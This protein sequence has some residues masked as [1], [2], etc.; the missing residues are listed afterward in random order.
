MPSIR[1]QYEACRSCILAAIL[2]GLRER[3]DYIN[4]IPRNG[5][6]DIP[7]T[8]LALELSP[9]EGG[10]GLSLRLTEDFP[11][12]DERYTSADW[13][14]FDFTEGCSSPSFEAARAYFSEMYKQADDSGQDPRE[15][16]HLVFLAGAEALLD[17]SVSQYL[18]TLGINA[19]EVGDYFIDSPFEFI[20]M[21]PDES[22][23]SNYCDLVVS[24]RIAERLFEQ[25]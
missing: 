13:S 3:T 5:R 16:A 9:W 7:A 2:D 14:Q 8:G 19:P 6:G 15:I 1:Q 11:R 21:D 12:G 4:S 22:V 25:S 10:L 24:Y 17:P 20:V 23:K 18:S